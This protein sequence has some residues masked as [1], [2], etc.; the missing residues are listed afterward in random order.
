MQK[1][2]LLILLFSWSATLWAK[3]CDVVTPPKSERLEKIQFADG[4]QIYM[5]GYIHGDRQL[6]FQMADL[7]KNRAKK[8]SDSQLH[9]EILKLVDQT[10]FA[11]GEEKTDVKQLRELL[12]KQPELKFVG[13][14]TE[15]QFAVSN[16]ENYQV[17][18]KDFQK[19]VR[20][21]D[22][23]GLSD[24]QSLEHT[25][26]GAAGTLR[27]TDPKLYESRQIR[28]FE[29]ANG[30]A[31]SDKATIAADEALERLRALAKGENEFMKNIN[32]TIMELDEMYGTYS[33][34]QDATLIQ[35]MQK[36]PMPD[37]YR[38]A[39]MEWFKLKLAEMAADKLREHDVVANILAAKTS[40]ILIMGSA[41]M[42]GIMSGLQKQCQSQS[43]QN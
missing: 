34:D 9:T 1:I 43:A 32:G 40:G 23:G 39:T 7:V 2:V 17:M 26:L 37:A 25:V 13:F 6:P 36:A 22:P 14:E 5:L 15:D 11:L 8:L 10:T 19:M 3:P 30:T 35:K 24:E 4:R 27:M 33:T 31:A 20:V 29:S 18:L 12:T 16:L 42:D 41:H 38:V 21:R 28:G